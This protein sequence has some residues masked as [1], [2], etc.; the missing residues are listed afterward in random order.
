VECLA[1]CLQ[2][3]HPTW[4]FNGVAVGPSGTVYLTNDVSNTL[5]SIPAGR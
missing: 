2:D 5:C 3:D 1:P 4:V